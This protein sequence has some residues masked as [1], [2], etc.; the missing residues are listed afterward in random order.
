[1]DVVDLPLLEANDPVQRGLDAMNKLDRRKIVVDRGSSAYT[2][3]SNKVVL[4]GW[5][6]K[7]DSLGE[8]PTSDVVTVLPW[9]ESF[10]M[11]TTR[12]PADRIAI[13]GALDKAG[14]LFGLL[15]VEDAK[16]KDGFRTMVVVTRHEGITVEAKERTKQCVCRIFPTHNG[17]T[18]PE[19]D[20]GPCPFCGNPWQCA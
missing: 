11:A 13:E 8:L 1:M 7:V 9:L 10:T 18:P 5:R 19:A 20:S 12:L 16:T 4:E 15:S 17:E 14:S 2:V 6:A 3:H